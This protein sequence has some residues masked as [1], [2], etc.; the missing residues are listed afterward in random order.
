MLLIYDFITAFL[1]RFRVPQV[2]VLDTIYDQDDVV[3][4]GCAQSQ[5]A[6]ASIVTIWQN[7][8]LRF[9]TKLKRLE[10]KIVLYL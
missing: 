9:T 7:F 10:R 3:I 6:A 5:S 2:V 4:T 1:W 8:Y